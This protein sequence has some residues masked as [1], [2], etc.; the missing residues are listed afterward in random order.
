MRKNPKALE[1]LAAEN[2][3]LRLRVKE[4][5]EELGRRCMQLVELRQVR[6]AATDLVLSLEGPIRDTREFKSLD[7]AL[8]PEYREIECDPDGREQEALQQMQGEDSQELKP[9]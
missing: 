4:T 2:A 9:F 7:K 3:Q 1:K 6:D 5:R 8:G